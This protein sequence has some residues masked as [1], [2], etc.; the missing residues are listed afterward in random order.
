MD[1]VG[2]VI[3]KRSFTSVRRSL[4]ALF[5]KTVC[6]LSVLRFSVPHHFEESCVCVCVLCALCACVCVLCA[7]VLCAC[8]CE[9]VV[10]LVC[11]FCVKR[12]VN[13]L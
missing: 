5:F 13:A 6:F 11:V 10:C 12:T 2:D 1:V 8:V 3:C 4:V 7:C 9:C